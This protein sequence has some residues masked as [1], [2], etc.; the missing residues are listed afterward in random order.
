[1][2][3]LTHEALLQL[4]ATPGV[5]ILFVRLRANILPLRATRWALLRHAAQRVQTAPGPER[6]DETGYQP[7]A[8]I[9]LRQQPDR[10][11]RRLHHAGRQKPA[12]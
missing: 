2:A 3:V 11:R 8:S 4:A 9:A 12:R 7:A 6:L 10:Q 1:M 5:K